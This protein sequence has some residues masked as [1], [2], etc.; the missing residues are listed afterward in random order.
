MLYKCKNCGGELHFDPNIGKLKCDFCGNEY[1]LSE[2][3]NQVPETE[4][5]SDSSFDSN[6]SNSPAGVSGWHMYNTEVTGS[7][8]VSEE[9]NGQILNRDSVH[10]GFSGSRLEP[11]QNGSS[12]EEESGG[13]SAFEAGFDRAT[14]DTTDD[15]KD[16]RLYQCPHCG[17]EVVTDKSTTATTC[18]FCN[19]PLILQ[20]NMRGK[21]APQ[22]VIP[23]EVDKDRI[24]DLYAEYIKSKPFYPEEYS[25]ANV[26]EK[27]KAIYLP[28]WLFNTR[29]QGMISATG[30][31]I[32][33]FTRGDYIITDHDVFSLE[34]SG[35]MDFNKIP[36]VASS[37]TPKDAMDSIEP[38]DYSKM[39][40]FNTGYLPGFLAERYDTEA[41]SLKDKIHQRT[42]RSFEEMMMNTMGGYTGVRVQNEQISHQDVE[43][44]YVL[45]PS[46][47]LFMDFDQDEDKLVAINGQTGKV[48]GN[49]PVD[50]RKRNR[51]FITRFLLMF[52]LI[53][54]VLMAVLVF[55]S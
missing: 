24:R 23:F 27:I 2:Y 11:D 43:T 45:L 29:T 31:R 40:P 20:E 17:A 6:A 38:F 51:Y 5:Y 12:Q 13:R 3:E 16:L 39:V 52:L 42:A 9:R 22:M 37:K 14:D 19:T 18:V 28:F 33:T 1:D 15:I 46:Y 48:I 54:V 21:F 25:T 55:T 7:A 34:R 44:T 30:E 32:M 47:L 8:E 10:A 26:I 35:Q 53:F 49:V 50:K 36:V 41:G 4:T